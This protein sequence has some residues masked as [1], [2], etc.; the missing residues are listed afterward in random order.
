MFRAILKL[1]KRAK[2]LFCVACMILTIW[3]LIEGLKKVS[4]QASSI[5]RFKHLKQLK[6]ELEE[7]Y[8]EILHPIKLRLSQLEK[9]KKFPPTKDLPEGYRKRILVTGGAGFVGS[10]LTDA[11]MMAGHEVTVIDNYFTGRKRNIEHWIGHPN[12]EMINHDVVEP[13]FLEVDQIYHL[14]SPASPPHYMYNPIKT[15][16]TNALGTLN[17]LGLAKRVRARLLLASTS[18][19]YG[20]PEIH[21]Q[22]ESYWGHVNT[23][24]PRACYDEGKRVAETMCYAYARQG[25]VEVR[26]ARIFNTFGT[27]MHMNDGRVVSNFILQALQ[28]QP[29]TIYGEGLQTRSFQY[30]SDL[31]DGL[32][33]LMNS[34]VSTPVN[35]GNPSEHTIKQFALMIRKRVG[36]NS[37]KIV[38]LDAQEDD[39]RK[40]KPDIKKARI[41]LNWEPKVSLSV[42]LEKTIRFFRNELARLSEQKQL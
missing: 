15:I 17:M 32:I 23:I 24:G 42:G 29:I 7:K 8:I 31:V 40:R 13:I 1:F 11:L 16:K 25:G 20:D 26:I 4:G 33:K 14:A 28:G 5:V 38:M 27:R 30:V 21:P 2:A 39:P 41:T 10:H 9:T 6:Q 12:F 34:N 3:M 35:L 36:N 18:E 19:V 37:S 22:P